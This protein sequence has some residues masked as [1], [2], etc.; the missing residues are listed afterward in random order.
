MP[1]A[2][3]CSSGTSGSQRTVAGKRS[4]MTAARAARVELEQEALRTLG[5]KR[6]E[7]NVVQLTSAVVEAAAQDALLAVTMAEALPL[8]VAVGPGGSVSDPLDTAF[9]Q[10]WSAAEKAAWADTMSRVRFV[11]DTT[12]RPATAAVT[13]RTNSPVVEVVDS[14]WGLMEASPILSWTVIPAPAAAPAE[15]AP[16][17]ASH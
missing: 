17:T 12:D 4:R 16:P 11:V 13:A 3:V 10:Q 7:A 1:N 14:R 15:G 2:T 8:S 5:E 6:S 9:E